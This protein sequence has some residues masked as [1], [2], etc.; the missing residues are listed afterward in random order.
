MDITKN[1][2]NV[3]MAIQS[4]VPLDSIPLISKK[5]LSESVSCDYTTLIKILQKLTHSGSYGYRGSDEFLIEIRP[6]INWKSLGLTS[7]MVLLESDGVRGFINNSES[8]RIL[9][10]LGTVYL[11]SVHQMVSGDRVC[12]LMNYIQPTDGVKSLRLYLKEIA[13]R[14]KLKIVFFNEG[15]WINS[16]LSPFP[17]QKFLKNRYWQGNI[18]DISEADG[19]FGDENVWKELV[20]IDKKRAEDC[21]DYSEHLNMRDLLL[22]GAIDLHPYGSII[23]YRKL[24]RFMIEELYR[25]LF[26]RRGDT[27]GESYI[28]EIPES[29]I[30]NNYESSKKFYRRQR[31]RGLN[32]LDCIYGFSIKLV[33]NFWK[34]PYQRLDGVMVDFKSDVK[35]YQFLEGLRA[36][37]PYLMYSVIGK[38][39]VFFICP[40]MFLSGEFFKTMRESED[41][42]ISFY[43]AS[44]EYLYNE[45][46]M[47]L[48]GFNNKTQKWEIEDMKNK[49]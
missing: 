42:K 6:R 8:E 28:R 31:R 14:F 48:G 38:S 16:R 41:I 32:I 17:F 44:E 20:D 36:I 13:K 2:I 26:E 22:I 35:M 27:S 23:S 46:M 11:R 24:H 40:P 5:K 9:S 1:D 25:R 33:G 19:S 45:Y 18:Q 3:L 7:F 4:S 30:T 49:N 12:F 10:S 34:I 15:E 39:K 43:T 47:P 37:S 21:I 29:H